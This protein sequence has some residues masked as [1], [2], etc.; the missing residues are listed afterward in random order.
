V[1]AVVVSIIPID[2]ARLALAADRNGKCQIDGE[3]TPIETRETA[4]A[5]DDQLRIACDAGRVL[6]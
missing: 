4:S 5:E 3:L 6:G 1:G 2:A